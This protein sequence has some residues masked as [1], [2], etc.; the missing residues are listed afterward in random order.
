MLPPLDEQRRIAGILGAFD[1]QIEVL[2]QQN[3]T[4]EAMARALFRHWFVDFEFPSDGSGGVPEGQPYRS[5]GGRMKDSAL[6]EIPEGWEV[7][8]PSSL[9]A[10]SFGGDWGEESLSEEYNSHSAVIRGTDFD[11]IKGGKIDKVPLRYLKEKSF[12]M[13]SLSPNDVIIEI[14]GGSK[15]Q[16]TGRTLRITEEILRILGGSVVAASF[17]RTIRFKSV[18][19]STFFSVMMAI[20]YYEGGTWEYQNQSTGI[21]NFKFPHFISNHEITLPSTD[22]LQHYYHIVTNS[23]AR[24]DLNVLRLNRLSKTRDTLL[25]RLMSG[26]L[27]TSPMSPAAA[28]L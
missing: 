17:C 24:V 27:S 8:T 13:K 4:L 11:Q 20:L 15:D 12:K 6:G 25:P 16:P 3:R 7:G 26:E 2:R 5:S 14:S 19:A 28:L 21:S 22:L 1:D 9:I 10:D 18:E 23:L